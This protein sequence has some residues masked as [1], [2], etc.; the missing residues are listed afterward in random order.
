MLRFDNAIEDANEHFDEWADSSKDLSKHTED[1]K[2]TID[3]R[4][5]L[6]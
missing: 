6:L 1:L 2:D 4:K 5:E 3:L